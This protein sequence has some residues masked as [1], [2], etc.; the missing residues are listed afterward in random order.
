MLIFVLGH[1]LWQLDYSPRVEI[2]LP[3]MNL[4]APR[5]LAHCL[6]YE[7]DEFLNRENDHDFVRFMDDIDIG[8]DTME[9]ARK[10]LR[11]M[12]LV[13]QTRQLRLNAGKTVILTRDAAVQHFRI[14]DNS[15]LNELASSI[16]EALS[17]ES[18]LRGIKN[19]SERTFAGGLRSGPLT[20]QW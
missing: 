13:L 1:L 11:S 8:V 10:V 12:D 7:L 3:Q 4:D 14:S 16:D 15:R 18:D 17:D 5:L 6:L 19:Q 20:W 9:A 2:G